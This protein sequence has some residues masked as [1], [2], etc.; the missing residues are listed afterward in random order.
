MSQLPIL[1]KFKQAIEDKK[2]YT[3]DY[4]LWLDTGETIVSVTSEISLATLP[5]LVVENLAHNGTVATWFVSGGTH[6]SDY[7]VIIEATTSAGQIMRQAMA[8]RTI[9]YTP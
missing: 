7:L 3:F 8:V 1:G 6:L 5:P 4:S 9:D 2:R